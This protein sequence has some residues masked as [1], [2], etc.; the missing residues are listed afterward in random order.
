M[1]YNF[2][3]NKYNIGDIFWSD[4]EKKIC[5][6]IKENTP[7]LYAFSVVVRCELNDEDISLSVDSNEGCVPSYK[8]PDSEWIS[9]EYCKIKRIRDYVFHRAMLRG[10]K[11]DSSSI[12]NNV[13]ITIFS[14]YETMT[15]KRKLQQPRRVLESKLLKYIKNSSYDDE[16]DKYNFLTLEDELLLQ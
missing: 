14:K 12:I 7:K 6:Y 9:Y 13:T 4:F 8:F 3:T 2:A 1:Y 10:I 5:E 11:L 15:A 16:I